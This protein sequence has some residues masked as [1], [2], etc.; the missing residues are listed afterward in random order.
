MFTKLWDFLQGKKAYVG[1]VA[2]ILTGVG[3]IGL[4]YYNSTGFDSEGWNLILA[5]W[6]MIAAKS[7]LTKKNPEPL[8]V[9]PEK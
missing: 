7:A 5:G 4:G 9:P 6:A 8:T 2:T 3:R 1:G